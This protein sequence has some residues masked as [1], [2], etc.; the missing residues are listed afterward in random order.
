MNFWKKLPKPTRNVLHRNAGRPF[1]ALA[2]MADVT[3]IAFRTII[4][5]YGKPDVIWTE[6][7][8]ADGIASDGIK[9][10]KFDLLYSEKERP[11]IV[12][13]FSSNPKRMREASKICAELGFDGIDINMGCPDKAIEKQGAGAAMMKNF[14]NAKEIIQAV[15]DGIEDAR[16]L[17]SKN[18]KIRKF[19]SVSVKTRIGYNKNQINEWIP[20]LLSQKIDALTIHARTRKEMSLVPA[21]WEHVKEVVEIR[22]KMR[23]ETKIIGNGDVVDIDDGRRKCEET[24]CDGV[25]IGR[26][27]F[28]N[29]WLF[30]N[31]INRRRINSKFSQVLGRGGREPVPDRSK[32]L[33]N[34]SPSLEQKLKV[35]VE[36]T[37]LFE[38]LLGKVKNFAI[39]KKHYKAYVNGFDGAK[40]LR[41]KLMQTNSYKEV[42]QII[43][44]FLKT[45]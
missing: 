4:T 33:I 15:K 23:V 29:P 9:K 16:K 17:K 10:L 41:L 13:L 22:N 40:E 39:M 21:R 8:S 7:V 1:F 14:K 35:L 20:F 19:I 34:S 44:D 37:K 25:M 28:G 3:D 38:K 30:S 18:N 5:K 31:L 26:A 12:Q 24:G 27:I 43:K 2:P 45:Y 36:H 6:F 32:T 11:I 42:E